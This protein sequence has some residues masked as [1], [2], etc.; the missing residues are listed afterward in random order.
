MWAG[1][2]YAMYCPNRAALTTP[3]PMKQG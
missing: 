2:H 1:D 3:A